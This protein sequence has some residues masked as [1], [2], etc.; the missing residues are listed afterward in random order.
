MKPR[1]IL[2]LIFITFSTNSFSIDQSSVTLN[3]SEIRGLLKNA[4]FEEGYIIRS[5]EEIPANIL[6]YKRK[7]SGKAYYYCIVKAPNDSLIIFTPKE[8]DGY[9]VKNQRYIRHFSEGK[10]FFIEIKE[11]GRVDLYMRGSIEYD[12]RVLFYLKFPSQKEYVVISPYDKNIDLRDSKD[13]RNSA[14]MIIRSNEIELK[15]KQFVEDYFNDCTDVVNM[16][17][18]GFYTISD[19]PTVVNIYNNCFE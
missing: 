8:I 13:S 12:N 5:Q 14:M 1:I 10:S 9:S 3:D 11:E 19:I 6:I 16:V 18:S 4:K 15:F 17:K 2:F 7:D